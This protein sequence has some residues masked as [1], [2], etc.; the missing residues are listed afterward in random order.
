MFNLNLTRLF[1][2]LRSSGHTDWQAKGDT[3]NAAGEIGSEDTD[4]PAKQ[5]AIECEQSDVDVWVIAS[6]NPMR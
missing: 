1:A 6:S 5:A 2:L 3:S 4:I